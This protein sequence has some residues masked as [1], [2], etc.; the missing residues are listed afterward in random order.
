LGSGVQPQPTHEQL[1]TLVVQQAAVI[2]SLQARV[3]SLEAEVVSLRRQVRQD[4]TNSSQ[5]PS[6]D[7]P[8]A[9][10]ER[11]TNRDRRGGAPSGRRRQGGQKG[12]PGKGLERVAVPDRRE[13]VE[14]VACCG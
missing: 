6:Q 1:A 4:S 14:P 7:G 3:A 13:H 5:P 8:A 10:A 11:R 9:K 2:E 12:H